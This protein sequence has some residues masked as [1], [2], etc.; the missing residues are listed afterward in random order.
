MPDHLHLLVE[1]FSPSSNLITFMNKAKQATGY[2]F[3]TEHERP[4]WQTG[5]YDHVLRD[6]E[7]T[8]AVIRY[9]LANPVRAGLVERID[10][11]PFSGS[12]VY[13]MEQL[14]EAWQVSQG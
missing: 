12:D 3:K 7:D 6:D 5:Y 11:Y 4:L 10:A 1:G 2:W 13:T 9:V 8:L 14:L